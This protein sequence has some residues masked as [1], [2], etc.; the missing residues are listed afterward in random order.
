M[1][2]NVFIKFRQKNIN[3]LATIK[4]NCNKM[5]LPYLN[6]ILYRT[7]LVVSFPLGY[8]SNTMPPKTIHV[9]SISGLLPL[10]SID[11]GR[12]LRH[13]RRS[14]TRACSSGK[15]TISVKIDICL[16]WILFIYKVFVYF[17]FA[18]AHI[19]HY[20]FIIH[21]Y[22]SIAGDDWDISGGP[23]LGHAHRGSPRYLWK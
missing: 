14:F 1:L 11:C 18:A 16:I 6:L 22:R 7:F 8:S 20:I 4:K 21:N 12:R 3:H 2:V 10:I 23:L 5:P 13:F 19:I 15:P 17:R 9:L